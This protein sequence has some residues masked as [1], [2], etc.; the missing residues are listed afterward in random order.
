MTTDARFNGGLVT[1]EVIKAY[2]EGL[3][4]EQDQAFR[5]EGEGAPQ[6]SAPSP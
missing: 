3:S 2:I 5:V 4:T 6:G 1:D